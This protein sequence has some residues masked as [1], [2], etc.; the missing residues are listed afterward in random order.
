MQTRKM[1]VFI[2]ILFLAFVLSGF[3]LNLQNYKKKQTEGR[4]LETVRA[5]YSLNKFCCEGGQRN[6][7]ITGDMRPEENFPEERSSG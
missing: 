7:A 5:E 4:Q 3:F 6:A 1:S 2:F